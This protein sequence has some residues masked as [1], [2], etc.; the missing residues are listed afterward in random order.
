MRAIPH[1]F[2][3][4][5]G[6]NRRSQRKPALFG[7]VKLSNTLL[8]YKSETNP[9]NTEQVG[10]GIALVRGKSVTARPLTVHFQGSAE[11]PVNAGHI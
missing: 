7:R 9:A 11:L 1:G 10:T 4:K 2:S 8:T 3:V 6:G 5:A